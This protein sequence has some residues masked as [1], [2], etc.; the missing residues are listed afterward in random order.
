MEDFKYTIKIINNLGEISY[1]YNSSKDKDG[2]ILDTTQNINSA[3]LWEN[4]NANEFLVQTTRNMLKS[5]VEFY[6]VKII[7]VKIIMQEVL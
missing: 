3:F 6:E 5:E 7:K 4:E 2:L 1:L